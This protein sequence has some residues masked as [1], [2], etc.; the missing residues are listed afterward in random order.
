MNT[1]STRGFTLIELLVV[2]AIIGI[3]ASV[4]L[5]SLAGART[6]A[7]DANFKSEVTACIPQ[8]IIDCDAGLAAPS[9][10][11]GGAVNAY[12][13]PTA[14]DCG[15]TGTGVFSFDATPSGGTCNT[16]VLTN[17]GVDPTSWG[18]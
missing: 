1:K 15:Q 6:R 11:T 4:V 8:A 16:V 9:C 5:S 10:P 13:V 3:L 17:E 7:V 14:W 12:G 2:I 18:C